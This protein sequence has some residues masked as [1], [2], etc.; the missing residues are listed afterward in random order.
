VRIL[1]VYGLLL[2]TVAAV[3]S[4]NIFIAVLYCNKNSIISKDFNCYE[5][6]YLLHFTVAFVGIFIFAVFSMVFTLT[7]IDLNP[8]SSIPFAAP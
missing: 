1:S 4:F 6:F 7:Y 3:P 5:G 2:T 8:C